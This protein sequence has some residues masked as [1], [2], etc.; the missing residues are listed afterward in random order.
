MQVLD[1]ITLSSLSGEGETAVFLNGADLGMLSEKQRK[2]SPLVGVAA[3]RIP[4]PNSKPETVSL[5]II[6]K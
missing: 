5:E 1:A 6:K 2:H 3:I 4:L